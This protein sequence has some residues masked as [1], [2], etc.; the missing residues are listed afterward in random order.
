MSKWEIDIP[1]RK[2]IKV[3]G[4]TLE[5]AVRK[6][7]KEH[8]KS[9]VSCGIL[10]RVKQPNGTWGYWSGEKFLECLG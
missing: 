8:P 4:K 9:Q 5:S 3:Q 6:W 2:R 1:R 7:G 10:V